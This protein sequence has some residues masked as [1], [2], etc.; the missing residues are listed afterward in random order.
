MKYLRFYIIFGITLICLIYI[1][2]FYNPKY[3][4]KYKDSITIEFDYEDLD[5]YEWS[6]DYDDNLVNM[7]KLDD[8]KWK[9]YPLKDGSATITFYYKLTNDVN[10]NYLYKTEYSFNFKGKNIYWTSGM[11]YG[12]TFFPKPY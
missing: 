12:L 11:S 9:F 3:L 7:K 2:F 8:T 4:S 1:L 10:E 6:I 5:D